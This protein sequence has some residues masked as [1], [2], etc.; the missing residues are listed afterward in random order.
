MPSTDHP[1]IEEILRLVA[2]LRHEIVRRLEAQYLSEEEAKERVK[3]A[4]R[5]LAYRWNQ[6][7]DRE[8]WLLLKV[9]GEAPKLSTTP[10]EEPEDE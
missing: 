3:A 10:E 4:L 6:V 2:K 7:G 8:R 9:S 5:E 1:T